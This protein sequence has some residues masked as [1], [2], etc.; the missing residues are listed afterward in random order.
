MLN[1]II[2]GLLI[3]TGVCLGL[4]FGLWVMFIG[5]I[6]GIA[7]AIQ[8]GNVVATVIAWNAIKIILASFVGALCFYI[9][10]SIGMLLISMD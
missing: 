10:S 8:V 6:M 5:G 3:A 9:P 7:T 1:K 2:G 4:Y